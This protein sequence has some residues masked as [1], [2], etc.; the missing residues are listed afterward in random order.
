MRGRFVWGLAVLSVL[1]MACSSSAGSGG[2]SLTGKNWQLT[3][4][5]TKV[6]AFQGVVP[7]AD[8]SK[9]TIEFDTDG[10]YSAK[11]DCNTTSGSYTAT[12]SG[13][14]TIR[15]GPTTMAMCPEGSL[16]TQYLAALPEATSY[17]IEN[18]TLTITQL[19]QGTLQYQ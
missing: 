17:A 18:G 4:I 14:L 19:D 6:P 7:Q 5:T 8:Q 2:S 3:A 15:S 11:A 9:Y 16:S 10:T 1:V 13:S 12:D